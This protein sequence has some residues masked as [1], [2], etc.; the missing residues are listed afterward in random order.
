MLI[1]LSSHHPHSLLC[2]Q[3]VAVAE[4]QSA[5]QEEPIPRGWLQSGLCQCKEGSSAPG[6]R[7]GGSR[8]GSESLEAAQVS[9]PVKPRLWLCPG[10]HAQHRAFAQLQV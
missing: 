7:A 10:I 4:G 6:S 1:S 2:L 9:L 8:L 3:P 5:L